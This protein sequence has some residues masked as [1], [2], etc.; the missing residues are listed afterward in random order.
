MIY[1]GTRESLKQKLNCDLY[2][3]ANDKDEMSYSE[4]AEAI[5]KK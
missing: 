3:Q 2:V 5:E 1:S 4:I